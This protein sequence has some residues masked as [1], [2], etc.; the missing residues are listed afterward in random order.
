MKVQVHLYTQ[1]EP[2]SFDNVKNAYTKGMLYCIWTNDGP[3]YKFPL[4][5]IFRIKEEGGPQ[6]KK[7]EEAPRG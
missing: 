2:C 1:S 7:P 6:F 3:I 5:H 4:E